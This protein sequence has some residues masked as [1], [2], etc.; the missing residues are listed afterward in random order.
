MTALSRQ[1]TSV[2]SSAMQFL[3]FSFTEAAKTIVTNWMNWSGSNRSSRDGTAAHW[4]R[5]RQKT[6]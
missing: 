2:A 6:S 1:N 3:A 4:L 5:K